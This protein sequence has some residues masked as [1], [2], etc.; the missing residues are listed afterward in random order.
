[1]LL[2]AAADA[3]AAWWAVHRANDGAPA[4]APSTSDS[5][6][7]PLWAWMSLKIAPPNTPVSVLCPVPV[8]DAS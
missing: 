1:L 5:V 3:S 4:K 7:R 8:A 2:V 6:V